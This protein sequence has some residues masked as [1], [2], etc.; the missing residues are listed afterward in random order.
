[1]SKKH[2]EHKETPADESTASRE[3]RQKHSSIIQ[4][5]IDELK[6][7]TKT[8]YPSDN[9]LGAPNPPGPGHPPQP[10]ELDQDAGGG[11]DPD[12]TDPET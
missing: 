6:G 5:I 1:V 4:P 3:P 12:G 11:D 8:V 7:Q 9:E 2:T 10:A